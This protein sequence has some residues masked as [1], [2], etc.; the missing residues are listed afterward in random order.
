MDPNIFFFHIKEN[1]FKAMDKLSITLSEHFVDY[2][3]LR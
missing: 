2:V 3:V 1:C